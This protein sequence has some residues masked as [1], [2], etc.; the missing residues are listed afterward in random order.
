MHI[1][2]YLHHSG[3]RAQMIATCRAYAP[4]VAAFLRY[5]TCG[6]QP[7]PSARQVPQ[8]K[9]PSGQTSPRL[10][11]ARFASHVSTVHMSAI[12]RLQD[13]TRLGIQLKLGGYS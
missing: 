8:T 11:A 2:R 12:R 1:P 9:A 10:G 5:G 3:G 6:S 7:A 13:F 4:P